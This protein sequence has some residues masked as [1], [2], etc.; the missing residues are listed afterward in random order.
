MMTES[1]P[2]AMRER[3]DPVPSLLAHFQQYPCDVIDAHVLM[4]RFKVSP[5]QFLRAL[6]LW[7][8]ANAQ[9]EP[10]V[11]EEGDLSRA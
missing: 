5:D 7:E 1:D 8:E 11:V 4:S 9:L 10:R 3:E 6:T 2:K